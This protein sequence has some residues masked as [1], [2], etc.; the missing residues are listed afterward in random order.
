VSVVV[1]ECGR[2]GLRVSV[3]GR[4]E[5]ALSECPFDVN[6][7]DTRMR[8]WTGRRE[9]LCLR[10][11]G[12]LLSDA[13][14]AELVSYLQWAHADSGGSLCADIAE[15][16]FAEVPARRLFRALG[17]GARD[18]Q[19]RTAG[20]TWRVQLPTSGYATYLRCGDAD[21]VCASGS[22]YQMYKTAA[23]PEGGANPFG[24]AVAQSADVD[25]ALHV[26]GVGSWQSN[27]SLATEERRCGIAGMSAVSDCGLD[28]AQEVPCSC[29]DTGFTPWEQLHPGPGEPAHPSNC[30]E[31]EEV[32]ETAASGPA[33]Q[34]ELHH[35]L[36]PGAN[37]G[38]R[39]LPGILGGPGAV[40]AAPRGE[41]LPAVSA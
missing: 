33:V 10:A 18:E 15:T 35:D 6:S 8:G 7:T 29:E 5:H 25:E 20:H 12:A 40:S 24:I 41:R 3:N 23:S 13:R 16:R 31:C 11:E 22:T 28:C 19:V 21:G 1:V 4:V 9:A 26:E 17:E 37:P 32:L 14:H 36:A 2:G 30:G 27:V 34:P 38:T 39:W